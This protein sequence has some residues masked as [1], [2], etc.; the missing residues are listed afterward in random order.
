MARKGARF[1]WS[2]VDRCILLEDDQVPSVSYFSYCA[3]LLEHAINGKIS[4]AEALRDPQV[5]RLSSFVGMGELKHVDICLNRM[6]LCPGD[7]ILL[8]SDGVF[9]TLSEDEI[10]ETIKTSA[11]ASN[12][13]SVLEEKVLKKNS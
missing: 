6:K 7:H 4:F 2:K 1:I 9:N 12:A 5:D 10:A 13:A 3:E 11:N 8:M